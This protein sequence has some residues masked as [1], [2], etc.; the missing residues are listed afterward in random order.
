MKKMTA[1][2]LALCMLLAS[3][4]ALA[5]DVSQAAAAQAFIGKLQQVLGGL[6]PGRSLTY[7]AAAASGET[8]KEVASMLQDADGKPLADL[9]VDAGENG[10]FQ[11][12]FTQEAGWLSYQ[13][14]VLELRFADLEA[15]A[16]AVLGAF[17]G[18]SID[19]QIATE[20]VQLLLTDVIMPGVQVES[21]ENSTTI[22]VHITAKDALTGVAQFGDQV[23]SSE[24]Y[25]GALK[26]VIQFAA[27]AQQYS[28]DLAAEIEQNWPQMKQQLLAVETDAELNANLI[29]RNDPEEKTAA[30]AGKISFSMQGAA[31]NLLLGAANSPKALEIQASLTQSAGAQEAELLSLDLSVNKAAGTLQAD[32]DIPAS[33][34]AV[35]LTASMGKASLQA[36]IAAYQRSALVMTM[37]VESIF[38]GDTLTSTAILTSGR[39][40]VVSNLYWSKYLKSLTVNNQG[41]TLTLEVK[42]DDK[43]NFSASLILPQYQGEYHLDGCLTGNSLH[44]V[45][46]YTNPRRIAAATFTAEINAAWQRDEVTANAAVSTGRQTYGGQLYWSKANKLLSFQSADETLTLNVQQDENGSVTLAR[47]TQGTGS[48]RGEN[49]EITYVPG[50]IT[51]QDTKQT[52]G[53]TAYFLSETEHVVDVAILP[54]GAA[55]ATHAYLR[56]RIVEEDEAIAVICALESQGQT[57]MTLTFKNAPTEGEI[58]LLKDQNPVQITPEMVEALLAQAMQALTQNAKPAVITE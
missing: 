28:G 13:G 53:I 40:T 2:L 14:Q 57:A 48:S 35:K 54:V 43:G 7:T 11:I 39:N 15:I 50:L 9:V 45:L 18:P 23:L 27:V 8:V 1:I 58:A 47:L 21:A 37:D 30:V 42:T 19:P 25:W 29:I 55:E 4:S 12:Q 17:S 34:A 5:E 3:V 36:H 49:W 20:L 10:Q 26:P 56:S 38:A 22:N 46:T 24:K 44:A 51:Y 6:T 16:Q 32:L 52:A 41:G 33:Q 31:L